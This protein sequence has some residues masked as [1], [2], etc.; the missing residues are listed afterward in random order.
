MAMICTGTQLVLVGLTSTAN[1][2]RR[3]G[4]FFLSFYCTGMLAYN[5]LRCLSICS[6]SL[7]PD[8]HHPYFTLLSLG[9]VQIVDDE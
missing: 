6:R 9:L 4:F 3:I 8:T 2:E 1:W 5:W 7:F